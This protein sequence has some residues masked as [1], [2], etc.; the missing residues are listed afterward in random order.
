MSEYKKKN[1]LILSTNDTNGAGDAMVKI[2]EILTS[3]SYNV[4][5]VVKHKTSTHDFVKP[6]KNTRILEV[7]LSRF[8]NRIKDKVPLLRVKSVL[9]T[10]HKYLFLSSDES[11]KNIDVNNFFN[12]IEFVPDFIF[13]GLIFGF[14]NTTDVKNI[15]LKSCAKVFNITVDMNHFTGG[16]HYAWDCRGYEDTCE[17]CPAIIDRRLKYIASRNLKIKQ[18]NAKLADFN[19]VAGSGLTLLQAKKSQI[20][21]HQLTIENLNSVID[22]DI[23]NDRTREEARKI[24]KFDEN[25][26]Y[27]LCGAYY[28]NDERKGFKYLYEAL[29]KLHHLLDE[30]NK[31]RVVLLVVSKFKD[32]SVFSDLKFERAFI[33]FIKDYRLLSLL[34]QAS[35]LFVN[36]SIEDSGP[37]MVSEALACGTPVVGFDTGILVNMVVN[38]KNGFKVPVK[39]TSALAESI[40][41]IIQLRK[42][43]YKEYSNYAVQMVEKYSSF[44]YAKKIFNKIL[45]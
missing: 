23:M 35:N 33:P 44:E 43:E 16:C 41:K 20:Y 34:Y 21:K 6:Y 19:I 42:E 31:E 36:T 15:A 14:L 17:N 32:E 8:I 18:H 9:K 37:M 38:A 7:L 1:V 10:D 22:T 5:M 26:F 24:F 45:A 4:C 29:N 40:Y 27:I 2:S 12:D 13:V 3:M 11:R 25:K 28:V 30:H 39:D